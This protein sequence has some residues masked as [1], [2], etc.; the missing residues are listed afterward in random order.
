MWGTTPAKPLTTTAQSSAGRPPSSLDVSDCDGGQLGRAC[1]IT[2]HHGH[3]HFVHPCGDAFV[4]SGQRY[5]NAH[6]KLECPGRCLLMEVRFLN[7]SRTIR[8]IG[9]AELRAFFQSDDAAAFQSVGYM[10][11][12][13]SFIQGH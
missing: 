11:K 13:I 1:Y 10:T 12:A 6:L 2:V 9:F 7:V 4:F 5:A 8:D 3:G